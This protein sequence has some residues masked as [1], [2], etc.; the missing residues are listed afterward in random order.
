MKNMPYSICI[1]TKDIANIKGC[2]D[3]NARLLLGDIKSYFNKEEKHHAVTFKE[4][5]E[6][7]RIP[8][9]EL[10]PFRK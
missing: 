6:Y 8:L 1:T 7:T 4:F 10:E 2:S 3:R 5:S 9:E